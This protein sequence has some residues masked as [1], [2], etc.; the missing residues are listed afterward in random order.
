MESIDKTDKRYYHALAYKVSCIRM[1]AHDLASRFT[2]DNDSRADEIAL[3]CEQIEC[4]CEKLYRDLGKLDME[5][6]N[7]QGN[8]ES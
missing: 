3:I 8:Q 5:R 4:F 2:V 6:K 7:G 1:H